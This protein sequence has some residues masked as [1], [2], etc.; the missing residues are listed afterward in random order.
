MKRRLYLVLFICL[1]LT[2]T[3]CKKQPEAT[4]EEVV[5]E[6]STSMAE[7]VMSYEQVKAAKENRPVIFDARVKEKQGWEKERAQITAEDSNG[8]YVVKD[9]ICSEAEYEQMKAGTAIRITGYKGTDTQKITIMN[10][11]YELLE[12]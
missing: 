3:N 6:D 2:I 8:V 11:E 9:M 4:T 12:Q 7:G 10:A 1:F 5:I